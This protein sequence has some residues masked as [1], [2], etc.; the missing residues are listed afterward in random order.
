MALQQRAAFARD[1]ARRDAHEAIAAEF[2]R[3]I[4][5][6]DSAARQ[7]LH[8]A[9]AAGT[10]IGEHEIRAAGEDAR[11][12][13]LEPARELR[14]AFQNFPDIGSQKFRRR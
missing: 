7:A 9:R 3:A 12:Q 13:P 8:Q 11:S 14:T 6:Q 5:H 1:R 2:R 10:E 4:A